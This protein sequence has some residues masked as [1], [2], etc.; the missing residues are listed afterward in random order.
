MEDSRL[1]PLLRR[2]LGLFWMG[3]LLDGP[4][5]VGVILVVMIRLKIRG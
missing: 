5:W 1:K 3:W 4:L 2:W